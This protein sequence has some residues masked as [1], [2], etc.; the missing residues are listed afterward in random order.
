MNTKNPIE[1]NS[2]L[3]QEMIAWRHWLHQHPELSFEENLTS[4][5]I[6]SIL[7]SHNI[8]MHR[9][10][11]VTGIVATVHGTKKGNTIGLRADMDALPIQELNKFAHKSTHDGKMHA[12]GHDGHSTM[13]LGAAVYLKQHNDFAGTV[14]FIFQ[15][16]EE[17]GAGGEV[18]VKEG[19]FDKFPCSA[20]YGMHNW[21]GL[22]EGK[23]AIHD[24]HVMAAV[25]TINITITGK[26][27]HAAM[28]DQ[29][30][31]PI[32]TGAHVIT[33]LQSIV[34]RTVSPV[35]SAVISITIVEAGFTHNVIPNEMQ[36]TGT[37][38]YFQPEVGMRIKERMHTLVENTCKAMDATGKLWFEE[39]YPATINSPR[40]A[41]VCANAAGML[42]DKDSVLRDIPP[43][44]GAE[45]FSFI[46]NA[47]E[48]AYIWIGN[49]I[50]SKHSSVEPKVYPE[51]VEEKHPPPLLHDQV[52]DHEK[53][54]TDSQTA[55]NCMLHNTQ[56]DFNDDILALGASYWVQL[57]KNA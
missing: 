17:G 28:P 48:G 2:D 49:G 30:I 13:L 56:Y 7:E 21:P 3:H 15:P 31:D 6:A 46:L 32:L 10:L 23:F 1:K 51:P 42:V 26:G 25:E 22:A 37:L 44:M 38:R 27:G 24:T 34:S 12:C 57:I 53:K 8:E 54:T 29:I 47:C 14:H 9:G 16:A 40:H 4:D 41:Q 52:A 18:M 39:G 11:A 5:Y 55:S 19:L 36:L 20:V 35:E 45:D 50:G 33:A 43:S